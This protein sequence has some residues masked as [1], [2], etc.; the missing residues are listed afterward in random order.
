MPTA[1]RDWADI[2][3][4][5]FGTTTAMWAAG[6][7]THF[8][9]VLPPSWL[10][11]GLLMLVLL[12]GGVCVGAW[13][14]RGSFGGVKA[15]LLVG[16]LNLLVLGAVIG[17]EM[18][19]GGTPHPAVWVLS[20]IA[21]TTAIM[22][23]G[24]A[25]GAV[26]RQ[27]AG[28]T[29]DAQDALSRWPARFPGVAAAATVFL[30][31]VGGTVTGFK[32]GL[33]VPDWPNS[34]GYNMFLLPLSR[35]TGGIYFEHSHRLFGALVGFTTVV[36][37]IYLQ[38]RAPQRWIKAVGWLALGLVVVQGLLGALRVTGRFTLETDRSQLQP[39]ITLAV[40][41]GVA[42]QCFLA[43]LVTLAC[44]L[45]PTWQTV[46]RRRVA[47]GVGSDLMLGF[48]VV[49]LVLAQSIFGA[50][51]R[52]MDWGLHLHITTAVLVVIAAG[53]LALR[54]WGPDQHP[55]LA[56]AGGLLALF[57]SVQFILGFA[58]LA[59]RIVD[60]DHAGSET[61]HS[62]RVLGTTLHQ[63]FG[64]VVLATAWSVVLWRIRT[65]GAAGVAQAVD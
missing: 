12:A 33:A 28:A 22:A 65:V 14:D 2:A 17:R 62:L 41:H 1:R 54:S 49:A 16:I 6:Y 18:S 43:T 32:A 53:A 61:V 9:G 23:M 63:T 10:V 64:A 48:G 20:S 3:T 26:L 46:E 52:H 7:V 31:S 58:A 39:N 21:I 36:L 55:A 5:A 8:P 38:L 11:F 45:S 30:I 44:G 19:A 60:A 40:V 59:L 13:T 56:R 42:A 27:P 57:V 25:I 29:I 24:A 51:Y 4:L 35:M 34:F 50:L 37:A 15:G 47:G